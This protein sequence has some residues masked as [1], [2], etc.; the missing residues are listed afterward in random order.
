MLNRSKNTKRPTVILLLGLLTMGGAAK[1]DALHS[2][3]FSVPNLTEEALNWC[4]PAAGQIVMGAYPSGACSIPQEDVW[5]SIQS[6]KVE[7]DWD[8]DPEGLRQALLE[9]C[10]PTG[11]WS[12]RER[13]TPQQLMGSVTYWMT[14]TS[15]PVPLLMDTAPHNSYTPHAEHWVVIWG[16]VTDVDPTVTSVTSVDLHTVCYLDPSPLN[17]GDP[18]TNVCEN[19]GTWNDTIIQPVSK[20]TSGLFGNYIALVEP[21]QKK[22]V[23]IAPPEVLAGT[24]IKPDDAVKF[25]DEKVRKQKLH[26]LDKFKAIQ[27]AKPLPPLLVNKDYGG[28][29][30]V[31]YS[32]DGKSV[33]IAVLI[34]AYTGDFQSIAAFQPTTYLSKKQAI[35][36]AVKHFDDIDKLGPQPEPP[37]AELVY[38]LGERVTSRWFPMWRVTAG[39]ESVGVD[40]NKKVFTQMPTQDYFLKVAVPKPMGLA[41]DGEQMWTVDEQNKKIHSLDARTGAIIK[42]LSVQVS[43]PKGLAFDGD[44]LWIGD[45][46]AMKLH[47]INLASGETTR[48]IPIQAPKEKGI[49]AFEDIAWDGK[50]LW[51]A[52]SAGFSSSYNQID[53]ESGDIVRSIFA[54]CIPRGIAIRDGVLWSVCYNGDKLPAKIDQR[55]I[56]DKGH[57]MLRSRKFIKDIELQEAS[58]L[59]YDGTYL[60]TMDR[61]LKRVFKIYVKAPVKQ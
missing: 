29:Y 42:T 44:N 54:D 14:A 40:Q 36:I 3:F 18:A 34:N 55:N 23:A 1:A 59:I 57:E 56:L 58:G 22:I 27:N 28:Y 61:K 4:G 31:P 39:R 45:S 19:G 37:D 25:A 17:L 43:A 60:W 52:I 48:T 15:Y 16:V 11:T 10:P 6:H 9:L 20:V 5:M 8:T 2:I 7:A 24:L 38:P 21:P 12:L 46:E 51:T 33:S 47:A 50:Y 53:P 41:W 49:K 35:D 30:L 32:T 26:E 13:S